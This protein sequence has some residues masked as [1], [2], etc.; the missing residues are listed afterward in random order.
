MPLAGSGHR[1]YAGPTAHAV[2]VREI[3]DGK[4]SGLISGRRS[5]TICGPTASF[6][7]RIPSAGSAAAEHTQC[8]QAP[9]FGIVRTP[10]RDRAYVVLAKAPLL[11][12][13]R[14]LYPSC[15]GS[16]SSAA[17]CVE[18]VPCEEPDEAAKSVTLNGKSPAKKVGKTQESAAAGLRPGRCANRLSSCLTRSTRSTRGQSGEITSTRLVRVTSICTQDVVEPDQGSNSWTRRETTKHP[19]GI[20]LLSHDA[21]Q[22]RRAH[23]SDRR[24]TGRMNQSNQYSRLSLHG[25]GAARELHAIKPMQDGT[26]TYL[27]L[28][29]RRW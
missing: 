21:F 22:A 11:G 4:K 16:K 14:Y 10:T 13:S 6:T 15:F 3:Q 25:A 2:P 7:T 24:R 20:P 17:D 26:R 19:N 12:T 23:E 27:C 28:L 1:W 29:A 18:G 5:C 9:P 8:P